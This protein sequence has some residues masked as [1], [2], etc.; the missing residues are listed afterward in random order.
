[1]KYCLHCGS[2]YAESYDDYENENCMVCGFKLIEDSNMTEEQFSNYRS[3][4][5]MIM[6]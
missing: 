1:M 5:R 2:I 3:L 6:N 4:K